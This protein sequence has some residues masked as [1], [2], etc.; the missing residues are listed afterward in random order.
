MRK[1]I[2]SLCALAAV[3]IL[4]GC[5]QTPPPDEGP[6]PVRTF[7]A[8]YDAEDRSSRILLNLMEDGSAAFYVGSLKEETHTTAQYD[9]AYAL[10]ENADYDETIRLT[11]EDGSI[12][13]TTIVDGVF[14]IDAIRFYETAPASMEGD[15]YVGYLTK[16]SGMGPMVY[17]YALCLRDNAA[18]DVSIMQMASVMHVWGSTGGTYKTK[19]E[20]IT[21]TYDILTEDGDL[22]AADAVAEG[23]GF[24]GNSLTAAFNIQ[25]NTMR[26]TDAMFI[27]VKEHHHEQSKT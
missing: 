25:Q 16:T 4:P 26:P 7:V 6:A 24:D 14:E 9:A 12:I 21:F 18:F 15:V 10:G 23:T 22:V 19:G 2:L 13:D 11:H 1:P 27:K 20:N 8:G 3:L 5:A 17:A